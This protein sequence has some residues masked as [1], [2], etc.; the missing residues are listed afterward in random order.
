MTYLHSICMGN[1]AC[2]LNRSSGEGFQCALVIPQE[3]GSWFLLKPPW[4]APGW[5]H[6]ICAPSDWLPQSCFDSLLAL[7]KHSDRTGP[8]LPSAL[9]FHRAK[10]LTNESFVLVDEET[11][12]TVKWWTFTLTYHPGRGGGVGEQENLFETVTLHMVHSHS[13]S[14]MSFSPQETAKNNTVIPKSGIYTYEE[15]TRGQFAPVVQASFRYRKG[16]LHRVLPIQWHPTKHRTITRNAWLRG[17]C[18]SIPTITVMQSWLLAFCA[19]KASVTKIRDNEKKKDVD[20]RLNWLISLK[21][22]LC[23]LFAQIGSPRQGTSK[24]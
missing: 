23:L 15:V 10:E 3:L 19:D 13:I 7:G 21:T 17:K 20:L 16:W 11:T 24:H 6:L 18:H 14:L 4:T 12:K 5:S 8:F 22:C 1:A 9:V 2:I